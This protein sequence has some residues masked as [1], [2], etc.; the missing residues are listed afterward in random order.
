MHIIQPS[1]S[2]KM[3]LLERGFYLGNMAHASIA[4]QVSACAHSVANCIR[5]VNAETVTALP[6]FLRC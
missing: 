2:F 6:S 3:E 5:F 1:Q 4:A